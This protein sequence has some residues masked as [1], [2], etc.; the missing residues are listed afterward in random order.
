MEP[1]KMEVPCRV[2]A[3]DDETSTLSFVANSGQTDRVGHVCR[4]LGCKTKSF[5][6][7]PVFLWSHADMLLPIGKVTAIT[8][9][10]GEGVL[11]DTQFAT[12]I[13]FPSGAFV[14]AESVFRMYRAG[15]LNA[16]SVRFMPIKTTVV[17]EG[18]D[19]YKKGVR[20]I[21]EEW[22]LLEVSAVNVPCDPLA[23]QKD[24]DFARTLIDG[25][26]LPDFTSALVKGLV[27]FKKFP[28]A[29]EK[30]AWRFTASDGNALIEA[31]GWKAYKAAHTWQ[32][33]GAD[34]E[35]RQAYKL[36]HHKPISGATKTVWR[37]VVAAMVVVLGGRGGVGIPAAARKQC[38]GHLAKHYKEFDKPVP[39]F[40]SY[41]PVGAVF[42]ALGMDDA[43]EH[44]AEIEARV[45]EELG[46]RVA[47]I[48]ADV[49]MAK[50][51]DPD[52]ALFKVLMA[53]GPAL[54]AG[55]PD[56]APD[57]TKFIF[58]EETDTALV[59]LLSAAKDAIAV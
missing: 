55:A 30:T 10:K 46:M 18:C 31:G 47:S 58:D 44:A 52:G 53:E 7:N 49:L 5:M 51:V 8:P 24:L 59:A 36:P 41:G 56:D 29:P 21:F 35:T 14:D 32:V 27:P 9:K 33:D 11:I 57:D 40:K 15:Y 13:E 48:V 26:E 1:I 38:H 6:K 50:N 43:A 2:K 12:D 4:E 23:L 16:V 42:A 28:L 20:R 45:Q 17:E 39:D 3:I 37:G 54:A 19:D 22:D 34:S 25:L